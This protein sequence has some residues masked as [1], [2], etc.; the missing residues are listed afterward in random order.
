M[1][2]RLT[3]ILIFNLYM[4]LIQ[5]SNPRVHLQEDGC[6]YGHGKICLDADGICSLID[7]RVC[8]VLSVFG[9]HC[10]RYSLCSILNVF[11]NQCVQCSLRSVLIVF[12]TPCVRYSVCS[13]LIVFGTQCFRYTVCSVIVPSS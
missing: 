10:V 6:T 3:N 5:F 9:I 2:F 11:G 12:G 7:G 8:T 13:V 1:H 4:S